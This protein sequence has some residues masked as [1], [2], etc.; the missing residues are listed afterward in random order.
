[1]RLNDIDSGLMIMVM[2]SDGNCRDYESI[3][4]YSVC[5]MFQHGEAHIGTTLLFTTC[6]L[7][8]SIAEGG[9]RK[10]SP[11]GII[12]PGKGKE[13][14]T[15]FLLPMKMHH[16]SLN[17]ERPSAWHDLHTRNPGD[18]H[19]PQNNFRRHF[20]VFL[21][22]ESWTKNEHISQYYPSYFLSI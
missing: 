15:C 19:E 3:S 12:T 8:I 6:P 5:F 21:T 11:R 7:N 14:R 10:Q 20:L 13:S 9:K 2:S 17:A 1:M 16:K 18:T 4:A 22:G